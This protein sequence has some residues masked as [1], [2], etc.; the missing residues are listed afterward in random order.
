MNPSLPYIPPDYETIVQ[1][2]VRF[3]FSAC[4][5]VGDRK[6]IQ[7][8]S[9]AALDYVTEALSFAPMRHTHVCCFHTRDHAGRALGRHVPTTMAMAPFSSEDRGLVVFHSPAL[10]RANGDEARMRRILAHEFTHLLIAERSASTKILGDNNANMRVSAWL[11][12]GLAE[13][14][15]LTAIAE[16]PRLAALSKSFQ[17]AETYYTFGTLSQWLDDLDHD[18]RIQAFEHAT[19]AVEWLCDRLGIEAVFNQIRQI[20]AFFDARDTCSPDQLAAL[21]G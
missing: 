21:E 3:H 5:A 10:D 19:G 4:E 1:H 8:L 18:A 7:D 9:V 14:I 11:N 2:D 16:E 13:V 15:G 12:E 6:L 17:T 20:N